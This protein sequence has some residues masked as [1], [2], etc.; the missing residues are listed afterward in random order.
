MYVEVF[1]IYVGALEAIAVAWQY[2]AMTR[3]NLY[4]I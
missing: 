1:T 4:I 3:N 2:I